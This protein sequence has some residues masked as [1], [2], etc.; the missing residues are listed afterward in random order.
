[1]PRLG[2]P[3]D[4]ERVELVAADKGYFKLE[5]IWLLQEL[6]I[7]T[8]ISDPQSRRRLDRLSDMDRLA[9]EAARSTVGSQRGNALM[10][11]RAELV[12][13]G[14]QHVLDRGGARRT[15]LRG[16]ENIRKRYLIQAACANLSLLMRHLIGLGTP[17]Q[18]LA[19]PGAVL[20]A[21][22]SAL[23]R[24]LGVLT[25]P[26]SHQPAR[27]SLGSSPIGKLRLPRLAV[28]GLVGQLAHSR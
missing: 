7:E 9:L 21:L 1:M 5:E 10:K 23:C 20:M 4:T 28:F 15:T 6:N 11:L 27:C 16:R 25:R 2:E 17:K 12:E 19:A 22:Y 18:A 3:R 26:G 24:L 8:A 13:R 14:F